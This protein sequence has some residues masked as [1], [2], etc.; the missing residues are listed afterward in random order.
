MKISWLLIVVALAAGTV[1]AAPAPTP[2]GMAGRLIDHYHMQRVPAEGIWFSPSYTSEDQIEGAALPARYAQRAHRAGSA[3]VV[4]ATAADFSA[5]HRLQTDETWHF[6]GGAPLQMLLLYPQGRVQR[7]TLGPD[8]LAGQ[9]VQLT[10]PRGVWQAAAPR[11]R[12]PDVWSLAGTQ[13]APGFEYADFEI[14]Y[15]DELQRAYPA[16][17][18][19]IARLTRAA[20]AT[21]PATGGVVAGAAPAAP[22]PAA[23]LF[24]VNDVP[25]VMLPGGIG[26]R[27][28]VGRVASQAKSSAVSVAAF[29]LAPGAD[30]GSS[31]NRIAQEVFLVTAGSGQVRIGD[32]TQRV[33]AGA[34][35]FIPP[36]TV[37]S[38]A[39]DP[40]V[41][42]D[43]YA[44]ESPA[45]T[46]DDYVVAPR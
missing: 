44:I 13:L 19:D 12:S 3:I 14:G 20:Y 42:L 46:P 5:L 31:Y 39:A 26:L 45:Y 25:E 17:A 15:R 24:A 40:G 22:L 10:V 6:Y 29:Q 38:I 4:V 30:T 9:Q 21:R 33:T 35:A 37:H 2:G 16:A 1:R 18:A 41:A 43:F 32:T 36:G 34:T 8:V 23:A 28:L 27:E 11:D 7:V